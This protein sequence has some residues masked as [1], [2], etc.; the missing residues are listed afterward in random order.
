MWPSQDSVSK[1][2][3]SLSIAQRLIFSPNKFSNGY[4]W[5]ARYVHFCS[6]E[7]ISRIRAFAYLCGLQTFHFIVITSHL[8]YLY[9][10]RLIFFL[11]SMQ[12]RLF[13]LRN[14]QYLTKTSHSPSIICN[15]Y[16]KN[17]NKLCSWISLRLFIFPNNKKTMRFGIVNY[18]S[19]KATKIIQF[20]FRFICK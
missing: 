4:P 17:R 11:L 6:K 20:K 7:N 13:L 2:H 9:V 5:S 1:N 12:I 19:N 8:L 18:Y 3:W 15:R 10:F 16:E 14:I